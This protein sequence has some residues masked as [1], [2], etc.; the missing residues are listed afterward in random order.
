MHHAASNINNKIWI[1][2]D[3]EFTRQVL[4]QDEQQLTI[5][6]K[7]VE[8]AKTFHLTIIYAKCKTAMRILLWETLRLKS[9]MCT[10]PWCIIGYFNV[11]S[12]TEE[13]IGGV[14]YQM[15]ESL[16]FLSMMEDCELVGLGFYGPRYTWS[17]G[18]GPGSIVWKRLDRGLANDNWLV[19]FPTT[20]ISHLAAASSDH[21]LL[22]MEIHGQYDQAKKY[23]RFLDNWTENDSF[24]S[25]VQNVWNKRVEGNAMWVFHQ[26][27]KALSQALR[28]WS[29][30]QYGNIFQ[31]PKEY[32]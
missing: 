32:E 7:H 5:E 3:N 23:F 25:L 15:S 28:K 4:D 2:W 30:I 1:F 10:M 11:I 17:N 22:L 6:L 31:K 29:R 27:L 21:S 19:S 20:T 16:D 14:P 18:K 26:K 12:S 8:A 13:K 24:L 9:T